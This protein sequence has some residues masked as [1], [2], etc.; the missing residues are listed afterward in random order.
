MLSLVAPAAQSFLASRQHLL[1]WCPQWPLW[2][3]FD[4]SERLYYAGRHNGHI[5]HCHSCYHGCIHNYLWWSHW[6]LLVPAVESH[7]G[8]ACGLQ[9]GYLAARSLIPL[10]GRYNPGHSGRDTG[11]GMKRTRTVLLTIIPFPQRALIV[12][13]YSTLDSRMS[14]FRWSCFLLFT[15]DNMY[16]TAPAVTPLLS[17]C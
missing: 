12:S 10:Y 8:G 15:L 7:Q 14:C 6:N 3:P 2:A 5:K 11:P 13:V 17:S 9:P 16:N 1:A 4:V